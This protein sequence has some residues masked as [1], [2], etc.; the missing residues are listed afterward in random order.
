[1]R[2]CAEPSWVQN[3][4]NTFRPHRRNSV[5]SN[6]RDDRRVVGQQPRN[7]Q[8]GQ[9]QPDP[10]GV[11]GVMGEGTGSTR[12]TTPPRPS[13]FRR[14]SRPR[15]GEPA[16]RPA[17]W[18]APRTVRTCAT[19]ETR[20]ETNPA[21]HARSRIGSAIEASAETPTSK[22]IHQSA[23]LRHIHD[24]VTGFVFF[25]VGQTWSEDRVFF[26]DGD[27]R[28]LSLPV[29]WTDAAEPDAFVTMAAGRSPFRFADLVELRRL[30]GGLS[31]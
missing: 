9:H 1:M 12:G 25:V 21:D 20:G 26:V 2:C 22:R 31:D 18:P 11:P 24:P 28:Q 19:G 30:M 13:R 27:G 4:P 29:G 17:R 5:S 8:P 10:V 7:G 23:E 6:T 16:G 14:A 15:S 3:A